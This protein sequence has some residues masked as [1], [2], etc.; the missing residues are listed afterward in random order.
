MVLK[1]LIFHVMVEF[2]INAQQNPKGKYE[3]LSKILCIST[4]TYY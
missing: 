2:L 1:N 4:I 3:I